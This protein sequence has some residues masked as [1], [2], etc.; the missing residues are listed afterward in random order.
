MKLESRVMSIHLAIIGGQVGSCEIS[1]K[2]HTAKTIFP[3]RTNQ[4]MILNTPYL[5][6]P[7]F[8]FFK[9]SESLNHNDPI[10]YPDNLDRDISTV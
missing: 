8:V 1:I 3:I 6:M 9:L 10:D 2:A 7:G 5:R 4:F